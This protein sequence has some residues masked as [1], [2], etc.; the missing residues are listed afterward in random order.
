LAR[1]RGRSSYTPPV[2]STGRVLS[3]LGP[4]V[5][6]GC[7]AIGEGVLPPL[8]RSVPDSGGPPLIVLDGSPGAASADASLPELSPHSVISV[9][10]AHGPFTGGDHAIVRGTGF[11]S[12]VRLWFGNAEVPQASIVPI[13]PGH[14]QITVPPGHAG[15]VD[16]SAQNGDD[17]STH[18]TLPQ[19]YVYDPFYVDPSSGPVSGGTIIT[20][21]GDGTHWDATT[22]VLVDTANCEVIAIRNPQNAPQ[23]LDCKTPPGTPGAKRV[24]VVMEGGSADVLDAFVYGDSDNG[25]RGGL[26]GGTLAGHLRVIVLNSFTGRGLGG[27][28]VILGSDATGSSVKTADANGVVDLSDASLG[29]TVTVT[30]ASRCFMPTTFVDVPVD[31]VT[32]YLDPVLSPDCAANGGGIGVG[33]GGGSTLTGASVEGELVWPNGIEFRRGGWDVPLPGAPGPDGST[34]IRRVAY[35]FPL[36]RDTTQI[37]RLPPKS[38]GITPEA[39]GQIGYTFKTSAAVGNLTLY[40]LAGVEDRTVNPPLFTA[41]TLGVVSG[42]GTEPSQVTKSVF[43]QMNIPLDHAM[44]LDVTGPTPTTRGPDRV[45]ATVGVRVGTFGYVILPIGTQSSLLPTSAPLSFV[46]LPPLVKALTG[47]EYVTTTT[48]FTGESH[49]PPRSVLGG[50]AT[51]APAGPLHVD[52]FVQ[53]PRLDVPGRD[54]AWNGQDLSVS[55][56][57]GGPDADLTL[58]EIQSGGGLSTWTITLPRGITS[59][60]LPDLGAVPSLEGVSGP[61]SITVTRARIDNFDYG[62]L[63]YANLGARSWSAYA[64]DD[65]QAHH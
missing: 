62:S 37:F 56:A 50:I 45:E 54:G 2:R 9:D 47:A 1:T 11:S 55:A 13:D 39:I 8:H 38:Q 61:V 58:F 3:V 53:I 42:V 36:A 19:G 57:P 44:V 30:I 10:P 5:V 32:A 24:R 17:A 46:G 48:A 28:T 64:T 4:V 29:K 63:R 6:A 27:A 43:I 25:F 23:E 7:F 21:H 35:V 59:T 14:V 51:T 15:I 20:L 41:Y 34:D 60:R 18:A 40:A 52:G 16:V 31:T 22:Q 33:T 49:S 65:F 12:S 26:S